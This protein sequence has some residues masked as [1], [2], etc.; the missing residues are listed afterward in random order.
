MSQEW[1]RNRRP[2]GGFRS[3][4]EGVRMYAPSIQAYAPSIHANKKKAK[5]VCWDVCSEHT[6]VP[7]QVWRRMVPKVPER[8][9]H[10][11]ER[12]APAETCVGCVDPDSEWSPKGTRAH[13]TDASRNRRCRK[14]LE[15]SRRLSETTGPRCLS[16]FRVAVPRTEVTK[17]SPGCNRSGGSCTHGAPGPGPFPRRTA[18]R[19]YGPHFSGGS[20]RCPATQ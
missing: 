20:R 10:A 8:A 1:P 5:A 16:A 3:L 17:S 11:R 6:L 12:R 13:H 18:D 19:A 14:G 9:R 7:I 4:C 15:P 2:A